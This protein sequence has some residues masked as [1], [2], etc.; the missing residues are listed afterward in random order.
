[1]SRSTRPPPGYNVGDYLTVYCGLHEGHCFTVRAIR[2]AEAD[3]AQPAG[4]EYDCGPEIGWRRE[5]TI[6]TEE[7]ARLFP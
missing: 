7:F 3:R 5:N 2:W 6:S 1:M 4:W